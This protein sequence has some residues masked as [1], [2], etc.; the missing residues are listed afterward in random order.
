MEDSKD[1]EEG[2]VEEEEEVTN[3]YSIIPM[4]SPGT[5]KGIFLMHIVH[6]MWPVSIML[7][8]SLS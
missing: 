3:Q 8:I 4:E 2:S 1:E 5:I 6:T 7:K